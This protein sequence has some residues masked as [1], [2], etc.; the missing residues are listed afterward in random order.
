MR[1]VVRV[2]EP[3]AMEPA[4]LP[5]ACQDIRNAAHQTEP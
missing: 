4:T 1:R 2:E 5:S 3:L